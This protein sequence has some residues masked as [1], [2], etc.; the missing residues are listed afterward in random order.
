MGRLIPSAWEAIVDIDRDLV[1]VCRMIDERGRGAPDLT[2]LGEM[3]DVLMQRKRALLAGRPLP[4][5][6]Y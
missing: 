1:E 6:R 3:L 2:R 5:P 4:P